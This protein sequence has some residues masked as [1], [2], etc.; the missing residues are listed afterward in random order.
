VRRRQEE[1]CQTLVGCP[2]QLHLPSGSD[3][4]SRGGEEGGRWEGRGTREERRGWGRGR[5]RERERGEGSNV[6]PLFKKLMVFKP[7]GAEK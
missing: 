6:A 3:A 4:A 1:C 5:E 2:R 7:S